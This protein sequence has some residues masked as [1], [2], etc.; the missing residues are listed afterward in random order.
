MALKRGIEKAVE[1]LDLSVGTSVLNP[2]FSFIA[3]AGQVGEASEWAFEEATEGDVSPLFETREAFY[4]LEL[5]D[6]QEE[7]AVGLEDAT[8]SIEQTL[9]NLKK[10]ILM[11]NLQVTGYFIMNQVS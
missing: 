1:T 3:G 7:G 8:S 10:I 5:L 6:L 9:F 2:E 11:D 4:M